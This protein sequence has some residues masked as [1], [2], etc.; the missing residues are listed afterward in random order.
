[1][2]SSRRFSLCLLAFGLLAAGVGATASVA[3]EARPAIGSVR[4]D[5]EAAALDP[6]QREQ[7]LAQLDAAAEHEREADA[8]EQRLAGLRAEAISQPTRMTRLRAALELDRDKEIAAWE[9]RLPPDADGETLERL[10]KRERAAV[11]D[12]DAQIEKLAS[13]LAQALSG[14]ARLA[15]ELGALRQRVDELSVPAAAV[16]GEPAV[17]AV[18]RQAARA[19][20]LRRLRAELAL[21]QAEREL[22]GDRQQ[23]DELALRELR[24]RQSLH[25]RRVAILH[26]RVADLEPR[27]TVA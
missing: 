24:F 20:E 7:A 8:L 4:R 2:Q 12:L 19:A 23:H 26:Q 1:M 5:V 17:V 14:P 15:D 18:A 10:L 22:A 13:G 11:A 25:A 21:G 3:A 27:P 9:A 6:A 16:A